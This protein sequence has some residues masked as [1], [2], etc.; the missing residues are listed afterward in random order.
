M[1]ARTSLTCIEVK[2]QGGQNVK[3]CKH[4]KTG[5]YFLLCMWIQ[6]G[7]QK[8]PIVLCGVQKLLKVTRG[9]V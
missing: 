8:N 9:Q 5:K 1:S 2:G 3:T 4:D 6:H 7:K